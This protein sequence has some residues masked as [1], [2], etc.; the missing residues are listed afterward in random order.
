[1]EPEY[2]RLHHPTHSER[3]AKDA[4]KPDSSQIQLQGAKTRQQGAAFD[5]N[6]HQARTTTIATAKRAATQRATT[7]AHQS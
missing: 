6:K 1:M 7:P 2:P 5:S 3:R 4:L